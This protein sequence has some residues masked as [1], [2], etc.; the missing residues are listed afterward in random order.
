MSRYLRYSIVSTEGVI[1]NMDQV[2]SNPVVYG[3]LKKRI[4]FYRDMSLKLLEIKH[5]NATLYFMNG[6]I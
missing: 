4:Q 6:D 2:L 5:D 1:L 3:E